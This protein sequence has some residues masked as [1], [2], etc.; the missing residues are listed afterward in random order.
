VTRTGSLLLLNDN[1]EL[2]RRQLLMNAR[3]I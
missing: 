3:A 2:F 1:E